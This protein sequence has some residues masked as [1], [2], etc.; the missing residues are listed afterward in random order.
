[1]TENKTNRRNAGRMSRRRLDFCAIA[2]L[3]LLVG[4]GALPSKSKA[5]SGAQAATSP[6]WPTYAADLASTR[7]KAFDQ[8]DA[9]NFNKLEVAWRFKTDS[10]GPRPEYKLEGTP[11]EVGGV[12]YAT[13]GTRRAVVALD[14][15]TGE[16]LWMHSE[17]EASAEKKRRESFPAADWRTGTAAANRACS[18]SRPVTGWSHSTQ[19]RAS[20]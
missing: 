7:Y 10:Y 12:L 3:L 6:D 2:A 11:L 18:T 4:L 16:L 14:A 20:R 13:A 15:A 9:S 1:M 19:R 8:I 5:Q 17:N